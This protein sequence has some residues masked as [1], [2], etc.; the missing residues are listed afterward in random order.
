[1]TSKFPN[2]RRISKAT[3]TQIRS[4]I[5]TAF[6]LL[7]PSCSD[8]PRTAAGDDP[9]GG[10]F[11][12]HREAPSGNV[13][14]SVWLQVLRYGRSRCSGRSGGRRSRRGRGFGAELRPGSKRS[15]WAG[16]RKVWVLSWK[17]WATGAKYWADGPQV[18][19][20][21]GVRFWKDWTTHDGQQHSTLGAW[22]CSVV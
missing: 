11:A 8:P 15:R 9:R 6:F 2:S 12:T 16:L 17:R 3:T 19:Q 1:M 4:T 14:K 13:P 7:P 18:P 5:P 21:F 10:R 20:F 22:S